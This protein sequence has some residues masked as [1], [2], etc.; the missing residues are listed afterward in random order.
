M[1]ATLPEPLRLLVDQL[2]RLPGLGPKSALRIAMTLLKWPEGETRRLGE[3]IASLRDK[4]CL[5]SR[6]GSLSATDPCPIC[7]DTRRQ[8]DV[9][10]VVPEWD[11]LLAMEKGGFYR[12]QYLILGG[13]LE[14]LQKRDSQTLET[15]RLLARLAEGEIGEVIL[16]LGSTLEAENT[17]SFLRQLLA[18][19]FPAITVSQL[20]Q[21][22]PLG[23]EVRFMDHETL[24]QSMR[25][26]QKL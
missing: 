3:S 10:C 8:R 24:R 12:G 26:R 2:A 22:I 25:F 19:R 13:L 7:A 21:G 18:A 16:A 11:S 15:D 23:A 6:C 9:L 14:P 20:A 17:V 1:G 4:L 5:C